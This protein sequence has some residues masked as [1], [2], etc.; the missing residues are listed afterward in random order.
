MQ[1]SEG[2]TAKELA[3]Q[4][5][6]PPKGVSCKAFGNKEANQ[7]ITS[8]IPEEWQSRGREWGAKKAQELG[9]QLGLRRQVQLSAL[10]QTSCVTLVKSL[11]PSVLQFPVRTTEIIAL[12]CFIGCYEDKHIRNCEELIYYG[13]RDQISTLARQMASST[14]EDYF[15]YFPLKVG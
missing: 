3:S 13:D 9:W 14:Q 15:G 11:I 12:L 5:P 4:I 6:E 10:S 2:V 7:G 8:Q 1:F